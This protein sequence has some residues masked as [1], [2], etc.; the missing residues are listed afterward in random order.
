MVFGFGKAKPVV[1]EVKASASGAVI[2]FQGAGRAAWSA[3]DTVSLT[4]SGYLGNPVG[5][6]VVKLISESA[7]ALP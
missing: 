6:R 3:R 5:F 1:P 7:A 4:R 2:A